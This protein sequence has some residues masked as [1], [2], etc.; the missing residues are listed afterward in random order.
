MEIPGNVKY[1]CLIVFCLLFTQCNNPPIVLENAYFKYEISGAGTNL[2]FTDKT[3][4]INYLDTDRS[5]KCASISVDGKEYPVSVLSHEAN[6][7]RMQFGKTGVSIRLDIHPSDDRIALKVASV[8]GNIESLTFLNVPLKLEGQPYEPF[9]ACAL[10]MNLFTHVR[11]LPPL[12]TQLWAK[13]YERF[14]MEG[15]EITLLGL[16]QEKMLPT[17][18]DVIS[19]AE[20]IPFSDAGGAWAMM[21][22]AGYCSYLMNFGTLTEETVD[23]WIETCRRIGFNQIDSHGGGGFFEFGTFDLNKDKWPDGWETFKR[24]NARL[25]AA[26]ISHTFHTY[27]FFIDKSS[28]YVTPVPSKDLGY[29]RTFTLAEPLNE[30][31]DEIVVKESTADISTIVGFHTANSV[32]L[33]LGDELIEFS[34]VTQTP[35]Y[36]FSGLKRGAVGTTPSAHPINEK[37]F[38]L[39]ERFGRFVPGPETALF[40]E[41]AQRH[42]E[43]INHC[44]FDG[45]YLDAIDGASVLGGEE[46]FWY[47]GTKFIFAI[48]KNLKRPVGMEMSSMSHHWWHFRSRWQAWDRPVRGYKRFLDIHLASIKASSLFLPPE[49]KSNEWEHGLWAGHTPLIDK[50]AGVDKGQIML[51][52]HLGWW[53]NRHGRLRR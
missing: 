17:I 48:A 15:A 6:Q 10:S 39:S 30:T 37:V 52:L 21:K 43:I 12:Q 46:N 29:A 50:Y 49:I 24:I 40:D 5:T 53:G 7:L 42:A 8:N 14:G 20:A 38:H 26:G 41:M 1:I 25:H 45:I 22:D 23:E 19:N 16:P 44:E 18:R 32:T 27:A 47:Y 2:Q 36:K 34:K 4:G 51:P 11:L 35:P 31:A 9:A 3:T 33:R 28:R 13:C